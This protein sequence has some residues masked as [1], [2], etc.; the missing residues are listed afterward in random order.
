VFKEVLLN[1]TVN[2]LTVLVNE[3]A[4]PDPVNKIVSIWVEKHPCAESVMVSWMVL[5]PGVVNVLVGFLSVEDVPSL[6]Y[7]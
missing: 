4:Q 7:Q 6:K 5:V 2:P 3:A 1:A